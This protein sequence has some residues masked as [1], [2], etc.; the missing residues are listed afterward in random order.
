MLQIVLVDFGLEFSEC[1][2]Y[3]FLKVLKGVVYSFVDDFETVCQFIGTIKLFL[4]A[5]EI[6]HVDVFLD[7]C[8]FEVA[9][10]CEFIDDFL[11]HGLAESARE[12]GEL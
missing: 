1:P 10:V 2:F 4:G 11:N 7:F 8:V 9:M 6:D 12:V 5:K 3:L